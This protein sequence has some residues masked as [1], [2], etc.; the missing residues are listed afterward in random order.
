MRE[1]D[2]GAPDEG[3]VDERASDVTWRIEP[4]PKR[5]RAVAGGHPVLDTTDARL[6]WED[7]PWPRLWVPRASL[8]A[9]V[10]PEALRTSEDPRLAEHVH[11]AWEAAEAWFEED[12]PMLGHVRDPHHRVDALASSRHV[13]VEVDGTVVAESRSPVVVYET[14]LIPR[15]YLPATEVRLD[16]LEPSDTV[17]VCPYKGTT[18]YHHARVGDRR[19]D[20]L[21]WSYPAPLPECAPIRGRLC[22]DDVEVDVIVDGRRGPRPVSPLVQPE[23]SG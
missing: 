16:L 7:R 11:L 18:V 19:L 4:T 23:G 17:T 10:P 3:A 6:V 9:S 1:P 8:D 2:L 12:E 13:L 5:I 14:G 21:A 20:D 15:W 22:F